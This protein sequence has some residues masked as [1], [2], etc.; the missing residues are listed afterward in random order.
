MLYHFTD[1]ARL[2]WILLDGY[3]RPGLNRIGNFPSEFIWATESSAVDRTAAANIEGLRRNVTRQ[4]RFT[5]NTADFFPWREVGRRYPEWGPFQIDR[6]EQKA[7]LFN[8]SPAGWHC[9]RDPLPIEGIEIH[10]RS[11]LDKTWK[12][13]VGD[14]MAT[15]PG[16]YGTLGVVIDGNIYMSACVPDPSGRGRAAYA[17]T[18]M[19]ADDAARVTGE[20][21]E[22]LMELTK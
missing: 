14:Q 17:V 1:T 12:P 7:R 15:V 19:A 21:Y 2:P 4:V 10:T 11:Y 22:K 20:D 9:R 13:F 18:K 3:L 6:L 5:L 8:Q 16:N